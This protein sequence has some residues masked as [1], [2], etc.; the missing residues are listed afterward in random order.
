MELFPSVESLLMTDPFFRPLNLRPQ[1]RQR[2]ASDATMMC[3]VRDKE[4]TF[5]VVA[6]RW[7]LCGWVTAPLT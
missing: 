7:D 6:G 5:E 3:D 2:Q 1:K 4:A